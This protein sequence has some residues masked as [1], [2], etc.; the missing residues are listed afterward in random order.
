MFE[1]IYGHFMNA[2][3][4]SYVLELAL[5]PIKLWQEGCAELGVGDYI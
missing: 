4:H 5:M 3:Y 2:C 1:V